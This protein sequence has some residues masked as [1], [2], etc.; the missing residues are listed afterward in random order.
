MIR[1]SA[2]RTDEQ[3]RIAQELKEPEGRVLVHCKHGQTRSAFAV[4]AFLRVACGASE[5]EA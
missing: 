3:Q 1:E 2:I 4:Y 5:D